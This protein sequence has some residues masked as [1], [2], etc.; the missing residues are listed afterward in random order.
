MADSLKDIIARM[1]EEHRKHELRYEADPEYRAEY[2]AKELEHR[3][4]ND[5]R[6]DDRCYHRFEHCSFHLPKRHT[7]Q[8][9][10]IPVDE[11]SKAWRDLSKLWTGEQQV[12]IAGPEGS[13]KTT[14]MV[15]AGMWSALR[16]RSVMYVPATLFAP[17]A[18]VDDK[19]DELKYC[20]VLLIDECHR[21]DAL[22]DWILSALIGLID[23]R[24]YEDK[25]MIMSGTLPPNKLAETVGVEVV[26]RFEYKIATTEKS[27]R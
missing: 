19:M 20:S 1:N 12:V 18:K 2:D 9:E 13:G 17:Y 16:F 11:R 21:M 3:I 27:Y 22:P 5:W 14:A 15:W 4:D 26:K 23:Y 10:H 6:E 8:I 24:Y 25:P 7:G